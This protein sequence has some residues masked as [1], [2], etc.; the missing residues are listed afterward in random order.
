MGSPHPMVKQLLAIQQESKTYILHEK[1]KEKTKKQKQSTTNKQTKTA[2]QLHITI[3]INKY[4][5]SHLAPTL[6]MI[7][8]VH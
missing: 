5:A 1:K 2:Q 6:C 3:H 7:L 4:K 8:T